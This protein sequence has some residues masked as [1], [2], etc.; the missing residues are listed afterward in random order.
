MGFSFA[1]SFGFGSLAGRAWPAAP[2]WPRLAGRAWPVAPGRSRLA[3]R[4]WR[5]PASLFKYDR[6][7]I[8]RQDS[9]AAKK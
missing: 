9:S 4:A 7:G 6:T 1:Y 2:G 8:A 5:E 3:G